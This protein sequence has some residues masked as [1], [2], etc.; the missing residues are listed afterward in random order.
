M[1]GYRMV[2]SRRTT[3]K[4]EHTLLDLA[5]GAVCSRAAAVSCRSRRSRPSDGA[6]ESPAGLR[7]EQ[8]GLALRHLGECHAAVM[9]PRPE[10]SAIAEQLRISAGARRSRSSERSV[11][12]H[13][14]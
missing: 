8:L 13:R 9:E 7:I 1:T 10:L 5:D 6:N 4:R 3:K 14:L 11:H 12:V 2:H